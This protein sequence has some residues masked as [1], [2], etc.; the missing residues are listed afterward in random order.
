MV[1]LYGKN[2]PVG[3][4]TTRVGLRDETCCPPPVR[5]GNSDKTDIFVEPYGLRRLPT[6]DRV[7]TGQ[8]VVNPDK[9][10]KAAKIFEVCGTARGVEGLFFSNCIG[11]FYVGFW[12]R[13]QN[14]PPMAR[15]ELESYPQVVS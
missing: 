4:E 3:I 15:F 14:L 7:E 1:W 13:A 2:R 5:G 12:D 8:K 10:G 9:P 11:R 6:A